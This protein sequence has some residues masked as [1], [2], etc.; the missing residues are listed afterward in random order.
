MGLQPDQ[1]VD[2][3]HAGLLELAR[4][5]DVRGLVEPGLDLDEGEHLLAGLGGVDER[6]TM[7]LSPDVR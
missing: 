4:P 1:A 2:D 5:G 6:L 3:V 7:G